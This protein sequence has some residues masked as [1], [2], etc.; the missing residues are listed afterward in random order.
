MIP[1]D[2]EDDL[3]HLGNLSLFQCQ[4]ECRQSVRIILHSTAV[5]DKSTFGCS[6]T[7]APSRSVIMVDVTTLML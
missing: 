2:L 3:C 4:M 1:G 6:H 7:K 5:S